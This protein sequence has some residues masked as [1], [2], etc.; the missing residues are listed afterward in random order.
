[1]S[2]ACSN[3]TELPSHVLT[4]VSEVT[5]S[6]TIAVRVGIGGKMHTLHRKLLV[7]H[8]GYFKG[9]LSGNFRETDDGVIP[10]DDVDPEAF[11][12]FV[13][14]MYEKSLPAYMLKQED[15]LA[16]LPILWRAY[17]LADRLLATS[18]KLALFDSIFDILGTK[19]LYPFYQTI[20]FAYNSL[21]PA[22]PLLQLLVD[23]FCLD[24]GLKYLEE[25]EPAR[26]LP[27]VPHEVFVRL[28][29]KMSEIGF[30][31]ED[32]KEIKREAYDI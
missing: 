17:P 13:D 11:D 19:R 4:F 9:A 15:D 12:A 2:I 3:R 27:D 5:T 28:H 30:L 25:L 14:W 24:G 22:D 16:L 32:K 6:D 23:A 18:F 10:L 7:H 20:S 1:V 21:T 29:L 26:F 8:S 31:T